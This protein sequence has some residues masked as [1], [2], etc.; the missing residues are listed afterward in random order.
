MKQIKFLRQ[1]ANFNENEK[2]SIGDDHADALVKAGVAEYYVPNSRRVEPSSGALPD[3]QPVKDAA[4]KR[5]T[6]KKP[7]AR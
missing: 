3:Q 6:G 4:G 2:A 1:F 7:P 5:G